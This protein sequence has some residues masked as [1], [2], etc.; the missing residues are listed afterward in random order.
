MLLPNIYSKSPDIVRQALD[1]GALPDVLADLNML[2]HAAGV[3]PDR[4]RGDSDFRYKLLS[5][6]YLPEHQERLRA[7]TTFFSVHESIDHMEHWINFEAPGARRKYSE[8][9]R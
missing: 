2:R 5:N 1:G 6:L 8:T 9:P 3:C 7:V 4:F